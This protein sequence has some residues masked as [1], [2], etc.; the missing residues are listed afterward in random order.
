MAALVALSISY[1]YAINL[2][3][4]PDELLFDGILSFIPRHKH[5]KNILL[6]NK[7]IY[8]SYKSELSAI[9]TL[10]TIIYGITC[11]KDMI[12]IDLSLISNLTKQLQFSE[13]YNNQKRSRLLYAL[14]HSCGDRLCHEILDYQPL[15]DIFNAFNHR[16]ISDHEYSTLSFD[17]TLNETNKHL[18]KLLIL[19]SRGLMAQQTAKGIRNYDV[20]EAKEQQMSA[21][22]LVIWIHVHFPWSSLGTN[23]FYIRYFSFLFPFIWDNFGKLL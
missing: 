12:D 19:S 5:I 7:R 16:S 13:W 11:E 21:Y 1:C 17:E 15:L 3:D 14:V 18:L 23:Y 8:E 22:N 6:I 2:S 9:D 4:F 10:E 20:F